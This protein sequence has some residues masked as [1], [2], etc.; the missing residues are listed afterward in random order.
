[1]EHLEHI[2]TTLEY[3]QQGSPDFVGK[4]MKE[5]YF[6]AERRFQK[7]VLFTCLGI[8]V[9]LGIFFYVLISATTEMLSMDLYEYVDLGVSNP[10]I[11]TTSEWQTTIMEAIPLMEIGLLIAL[12][13][14]LVFLLRKS[15]QLFYKHLMTPYAS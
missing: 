4:V 8:V 10:D 6:R 9:T 13:V 7:Q 5:I 15:I 3:T 14:L 11:I 1:M 12:A 2:L